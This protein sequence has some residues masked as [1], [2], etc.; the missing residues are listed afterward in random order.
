[1]SSQQMDHYLSQRKRKRRLKPS[2]V[3]LLA[4]LLVVI[5]LLLVGCGNLVLAVVTLPSWDPSKLTGSQSTIIYDRYDQQA[6]QVFANENRT[7]VPL[8]E[9]PPYLPNAFVAAEDNRF[10]QHAGLDPVGIAR[11]LWVDLRGG[12][13]AEGGSTITQQLVRSAYLSD[14]KSLRRKIQEA[15]LALEVER[16]YSKQQIL[17]FYLNRIYFGNG[18][19]G[20]Q[21]AAQL[22][23]DKDAK[24]LTLAESALLTG[25]V[26]SPN[27]YNPF[28]SPDLAK[29]R[30]E[31]VLAQMV[32]YGKITQDQAEQAE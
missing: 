28:A 9:L 31:T 4:F 26:R 29:R 2:R 5:G 8:A 32:K 22:Y 27:N 3:V 1:M 20:I 23:F 7:P 24:D 18:A 12:S 21:A 11:A 15:I 13:A 10:Y 14:E 19:Y 17:E 6:S 30:Q 25:I 16:H